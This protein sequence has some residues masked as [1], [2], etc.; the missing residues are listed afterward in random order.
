M[1]IYISKQIMQSNGKKAVNGIAA[2][3][4]LLLLSA[5]TSV[6]AYQ[7][8][9]TFRDCEVCPKMVVLPAGKFTMGSPE[10]ERGRYD[11]EGPQHQVTIPKP[12]AVGKYEVT[13]EQYAEFVRE[14]KHKAGSCDVPIGKSWNDPGFDQTNNHPVVCV[15]WDDASTHVYWLSMKTGHE[16]RLLTEAEWEYAARAGTT[17][18][19]H[20]GRMILGNQANYNNNEGTA[21]VGSFHANALGLHD[22]HGNVIEWVEDCWHDDY[23]GALTNGSAW[24]SGCRKGNE[25]DCKA[26]SENSDWFRQCKEWF[27]G[28][29]LRVL[30]GG[31]WNRESGNLRSAFRSWSRAA[32]R[33]VYLGFRVARTLTP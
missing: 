14:T 32:D 1:K 6:N 16:Y 33:S 28:K 13:V 19:Y 15:N 26:Y 17:T 7:V 18:A 10:G 21:A 27:V 25:D 22:M 8:G 12:F 23:T 24:L 9:E 20:F 2:V 4:F 29:E 31:S 30:R 5:L 11:S 3:L